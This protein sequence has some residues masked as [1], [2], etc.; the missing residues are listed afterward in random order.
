[1]LEKGNLSRR[2][3]M[4]RSLAGL[5]AAGVPAWFAQELFA[6]EAK[7]AAAAK[8]PVGANG[9]LNVALVGCGGQGRH[10]M[11]LAMR[12]KNVKVVAVCDVD[13]NHR[14]QTITADLKGSKDV[15]DYEDFRDCLDRK[16]VDVAIIGTPDHWHTLI[17]IDAMRK[18]KDVY[19]EKPL[20]LT[21]E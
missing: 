21:I 16:D 11:R 10:D 5:A 14:K 3:V 8:K 20:T 18:G 7:E 19:C 17:A 13:K 2:G 6:F 4:Q 15:K 9:K 1:M 12:D